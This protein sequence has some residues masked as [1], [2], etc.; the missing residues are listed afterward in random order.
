M[1]GIKNTNWSL[2]FPFYPSEG[3][4]SSILVTLSQF[5]RGNNR[6]WICERVRNKRNPALLILPSSFLLLS[7]S[8]HPINQIA[9][10]VRPPIL[11]LLY[12]SH[13]SAF[14][15]DRGINK[16]ECGAYI[17]LIKLR[18]SSIQWVGRRACGAPQEKMLF[19]PVF[20]SRLLVFPSWNLVAL[21]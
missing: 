11:P 5:T 20:L 10:P 6:K 14:L 15:R 8:P 17:L 7:L 12:P 2:S 13:R 4:L 3:F 1:K 9:S 16:M 18:S 21:L 19:I